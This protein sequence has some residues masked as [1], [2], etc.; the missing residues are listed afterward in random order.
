MSEQ[1]L[2]GRA[3]ARRRWACWS[4]DPRCCRCGRLTAWPRGFELDH[5]V[6]LVN[7][8]EDTEENSQVLCL[9]CHKVKTAEDLGTTYRPPIGADGYP[10]VEARVRTSQS[11]EQK[12]SAQ[13]NSAGLRVEGGGS[14]V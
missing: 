10:V 14:K 13:K 3:L 1:R 8:G 6:A 2:R 5:K 12:F 9:E 4:D 11:A 7:G